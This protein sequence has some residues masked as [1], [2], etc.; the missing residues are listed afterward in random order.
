V[1][2]DNSDSAIPASKPSSAAIN[3]KVERI[4]MSARISE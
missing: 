2:T 3:A 4:S 1:G